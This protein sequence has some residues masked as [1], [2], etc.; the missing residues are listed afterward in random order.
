MPMLSIHEEWERS[1]NVGNKEMSQ[2]KKVFHKKSLGSDLICLLMG[3]LDY[4]RPFT[5]VSRCFG[6]TFF[7]AFHNKCEKNGVWELKGNTL[8]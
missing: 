1:Q 4:E 6:I 3:L 7:K 2:F 8:K 5:D